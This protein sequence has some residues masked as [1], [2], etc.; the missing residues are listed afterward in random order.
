MMSDVKIG[1]ER[2]KSNELA[3]FIA[4]CNDASE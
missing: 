2:V 1:K 4:V 3:F